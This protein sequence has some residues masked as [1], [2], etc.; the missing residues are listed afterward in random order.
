M[1]TTF[2]E[3]LRDAMEKVEMS[4]A[5]LS[6][7]TGASKASISQYLSGRNTPGLDR[8]KAI[9]DA[10]G[11]SFDYL[12]GYGTPPAGAKQPVRKISVRDA[13]RC[14]GK[15]EQF[16]RVGLQRGALSFGSAVPGVGARWNYYINP[17]RFRNYVGTEQFNEY[18]GITEKQGG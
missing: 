2:A 14:M 9:A 12:I 3:R 16:I 13:A 17:T 7:L 5:E 10:T 4:Q 1:S 18:F 11:A 8:I 6:F 15:S